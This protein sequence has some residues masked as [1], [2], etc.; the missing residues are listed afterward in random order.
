M[1]RN[2]QILINYH[3][4]GTSMPNAVDVHLGE[5]VVRHNDETPELLIKTNN[6]EFAKFVDSKAVETVVNTAK[7]NLQ[8]VIDDVDAKAD[9][10][11]NAISALTENVANT[12]ATSASTVAAINAARSGATSDAKAYTDSAKTAAI[13]AASAYTDAQLN[14]VK[15]EFQGE[16]DAIEEKIQKAN[17]GT[18]ELES[19]VVENYVTSAD[20]VTAIDGAKD[21]AIEAANEYTDSAKDEA[22]ATASAYT[23]SQVNAAKDDLQGVIDDVDAKADANANAISVLTENVAKTYATSANTV[24]AINGAKDAA[25]EAANEYTDSAKDEAIATASAYT[26]TQI[27]AAK[28]DLQDVID[29]VEAKADANTAA[30]S[31]LTEDV[32]K[33][34]ATSANTVAAI[35]AAKTSAVTEANKYTDS[36]K[37]AAIA[38]ASAYTDS[39][40]KAAKDDL[41][42]AIDD[43]QNELTSGLTSVRSDLS[44]TTEDLT[45]LINNKVATAYRFQGSCTYA[46]LASKEKVNGYV[47]N[48]T[49]ANG[50]FPAGTNYAWSETDGKWDALGGSVDLSPYYKTADFEV[51]E[52]DVQDEF[53]SVK[54]MIQAANSGTS[55]LE[56][57]VEANYATS[58]DTVT[59]INGAKDAAIEAANEYTDSA[60]DEAIATASAYTDTQVSKA[61]GDLQ[62]AIDDV[63]AKADANTDAISA[64]TENVAKTYATSANT[65]AAIN[66]AKTSA[67]TEANKYT[68]SAK[69]AA[70]AAASAYTDTQIEA[71]K[72]DLQ[73]VIDDVEAKADANTKSISALSQNITVTYA[74]SANTVAAINAAKTSAVTEANKYTDSAKTA[75]IAA[76]SAYTDT[77]VKAAKDDLQDAIDDVELIA[78]TLRDTTIPGVKATADSAIQTASANEASKVSITKEGTE[79]KFDF[80]NLVIDCGDF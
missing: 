51:F 70:I 61:K 72:D 33:T 69:T 26:D 75:A 2:N 45:E 1:A 43:L 13:A 21:A 52:Q 42:D 62:D 55:E 15:D 71:A 68:D 59:A 22:I 57:F 50:N 78:T 35:N 16:I 4:S 49:D 8:D 19:F 24:A 40:V 47:W 64:L 67:V 74:T 10:N 38:A 23:D 80:S 31:A 79:L 65:V 56:S 41:Q 28:N 32:A 76:A 53:D 6:G 9:A 3:T 54:E 29:D 18:S 39:Q 77:Q 48:V 46:E 36:A 20:T 44:A 63:E 34:Y 14:I 7:N 58:A 5:V 73:G 17:S 27:E 30:I 25:I 11:A 37:T 12:Y 60:K 66:A